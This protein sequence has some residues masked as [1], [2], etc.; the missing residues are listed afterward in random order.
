MWVM[1]CHSDI[2]KN[3]IQ[4]M[5]TW[6]SFSEQ[7]Y[8]NCFSCFQQLAWWTPLKKFFLLHSQCFT[9]SFFLNPLLG[10]PAGGIVNVVTILLNK[11][12]CLQYFLPFHSL[13]SEEL[14][15]DLLMIFYERLL[16]DKVIYKIS[17]FLVNYGTLWR[18]S[19]KCK[20]TNKHQ[21]FNLR[22]AVS[23]FNKLHLHLHFTGCFI[24][25]F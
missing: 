13:S 4:L 16:S 6:Y 18:Q 22:A 19:K 1:K 10:R 23:P 5:N 21:I 3:V 14:H 15:L 20:Q 7:R 12:I 9:L 2:P 25:F 17:L 11:H 8:P 24:I